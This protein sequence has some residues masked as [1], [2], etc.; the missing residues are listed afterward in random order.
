MSAGVIIKKYTGKDG[1][2][3]TP[4]SSIGLK[5]VDTCVP[6]VYSSE[7]LQGTGMTVPA[8]D[9][10][11]AALYCIYRPDDPNCYAYSMESVFKIHLTNPPDVQLSN[12][13]I[14]PI[15]ERPTDPLAAK[16]YIGNSISYSR[17]TNQKS[18]IAVNDI[19]NYSKEH[20]F[21]L[22]VAG[23]YGQYPDQRLSRKKYI[24]EYKDCGYGNVI[25][26]NGDRQPL[27]PIPS[28]TDP[29]RIVEETGEP[30]RIE[31]V[32]NSLNPVA[33]M[34]QFLP[35]VDGKFDPKRTL[36][37]KY[38]QV[39]G[40]SVFLIIYGKDPVTGETIDLMN[41]E[42][43]FGLV[44]KIP[45]DPYGDPKFN[46]GHIIVPARLM[47]TVGQ[48]FVPTFIRPGT[49]LHE[50]YVPNDGWFKTDFD[51]N[52]DPIYTSV[53]EEGRPYYDPTQKYNGKPMEVYEVTAECDD[54]GQFCYLVGGVRRPMLTLDL[55]KVYRFVNH[56]G[57]QY[58]LRFIG[59]PH[60][61]IANYINDVVVDGVVVYNGGTNEE[62]IEIDPEKVLKAGKCINAYQC[63]SRPGMGSYV[64]NQQLFM[65]GQYNM[66]RVDG[67]I[68]NP[69]QAGE[70]DYVYLQLEV[71]GNSNPGY[72]VPDIAI[73]Y[74]EN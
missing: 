3:G 60:S 74:D 47:N 30:I 13:R 66:C 42:G 72:C 31:F 57:G 27:I 9:A 68:Y 34:I 65:C 22:T 45:G 29:D 71:S 67:G 40:N 10:S 12:I 25:Y 37:P 43:K 53:P 64:F 56:A 35:Y 16:L 33:S 4:V 20:P 38:V 61:P 21:Y 6:S 7:Q 70:T 36:D 1:D 41:N 59:N 2:F 69:L 14:Y 50:I 32:N 5:R 62:V 8:D 46:T 54:L 24:V 63:V 51:A 17:P 15:G 19:W 44:Y 58:P 28:Y 52:G 49:P 23:L 11:E 55:N 26:L 73:A 39:E 18:G 48:S